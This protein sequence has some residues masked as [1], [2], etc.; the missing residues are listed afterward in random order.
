[1]SILCTVLN[2]IYSLKKFYLNRF[3]EPSGSS[4]KTIN[5][6]DKKWTSTRKI[7]MQ[8]LQPFKKIGG[9][10]HSKEA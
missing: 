3:F 1:M 5:K 2:L 4:L 7:F 10:E 9:R 6:D 8:I